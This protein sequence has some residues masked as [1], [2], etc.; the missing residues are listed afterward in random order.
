MDFKTQKKLEYYLIKLNFNDYKDS[1]D[2]AYGSGSE[3]HSESEYDSDSEYISVLKHKTRFNAQS[4]MESYIRNYFN[5]LMDSVFEDGQFIDALEKYSKNGESLSQVERETIDKTLQD[6][7]KTFITIGDQ[8]S[9]PGMH[10]KL[11]F[12]YQV[13]NFIQE[14]YG[15][16]IFE[17][18][19][20]VQDFWL[21][22]NSRSFSVKLLEHAQNFRE[23]LY[24]E[25]DKTE[26]PMDLHEYK[27]ETIE[28]LK[29][30][31]LQL[32]SLSSKTKELAQLYYGQTI[33]GYFLLDEITH[34]IDERIG[35]LMMDMLEADYHQSIH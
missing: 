18:I 1:N 20:L 16:E 5:T 24:K 7:C 29:S 10:K 33:Y 34:E 35:S 4:I 27:S 32:K 13:L 15:K 11:S 31:Y 22:F 28:K 21:K 6:L 2:S 25:I 23:L 3:Y 14:N 12:I 19:D 9:F 30:E 26:N 8:K 17:S